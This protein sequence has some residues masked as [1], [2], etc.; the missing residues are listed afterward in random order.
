MENCEPDHLTLGPAFVSWLFEDAERRGH[1]IAR[2]SVDSSLESTCTDFMRKMFTFCRLVIETFNFPLWCRNSQIN[3]YVMVYEK[4]T[5]L[6]KAQRHLASKYSQSALVCDSPDVQ[7][8]TEQEEETVWTNV[9]TGKKRV[10]ILSNFSLFD[11]I[12]VIEKGRMYL[13]MVSP[14]QRIWLLDVWS[15][16]SWEEDQH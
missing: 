14:W 13:S 12:V 15:H 7:R 1:V 9:C 2:H 16:W 4:L 10:Q 5:I 11:I 6:H 3:T 8:M